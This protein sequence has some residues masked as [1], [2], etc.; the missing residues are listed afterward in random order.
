MH[1]VFSC[2]TLVETLRI[3]Y[4]IK[5]GAE[6]LCSLLLAKGLFSSQMEVCDKID[7]ACIET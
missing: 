7:F 3:L 5:M 4:I 2:G 1:C 6:R